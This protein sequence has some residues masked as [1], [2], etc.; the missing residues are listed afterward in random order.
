MRI[1]FLP[2]DGR[3]ITRDAF[4]ALAQSA[5]CEVLTPD[6][7][8]LGEVKAP[9]DIEALWRWVNGPGVEAELLIASA[10]LLIYGGLVPSRIGH[11]PL[12]R[13]LGLAARFDDARRTAPHRRMFVAASNMRLPQAADAAEEP[14][15]WAKYGPEIFALSFHSDRCAETGDAASCRRA[16][17]AHA[18]V[19]PAVL[20][21]VRARR[22]RNLAVLLSLVDL[23]GR[24]TLDA[25]LV[26]QD[27]AAPFGWTRR[28]LRAVESAI[29]DRGASPRAWVT[30]GTDELAVRLLARAVLAARDETPSVGVVYAFPDR[31]E[32]IPRYEG[33]AIDA[34]VTSHIVTAGC[35]RVAANPDLLLAV[36]NF[37]GDQEEAPDQTPYDLRVLDGLVEALGGAAAAGRPCGLADV[38]YSNGADRTL[39]ARLVAAPNAY[40]IRAYGG[41]NTMSNTL[42]MVLAQALLARG[43]SGRAFTILRLLDD[44]GYQAGVRQRLAAEILPDYP[45]AAAQDIAGAYGACQAAARRW[46]E[47]EYVPPLDRCFGCRIAIDRV[48]FPWRRLFHVDLG[49]RVD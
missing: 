25:L 44:W 28:D 8:L 16:E 11:E 37:P 35:R 29:R 4:L 46:L 20:A 26:G 14:E 23:A 1:A 39:V 10:E 34:T 6:R 38:R 30:Y 13:C 32:A 15:Y 5:G 2:L 43:A 17:A 49:I 3:P 27:D 12:D 31:R 9:A 22:A 48:D 45:G 24:G 7:R 40:G 42:G 41:W 36:N 47:A 33:Q 21:D 19:P 18:A